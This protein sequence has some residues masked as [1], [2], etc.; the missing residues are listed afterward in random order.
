MLVNLNEE[1]IEFIMDA[2]SFYEDAGL[3][4][5]EDVEYIELLLKE[6]PT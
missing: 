5:L 1:Q 6:K 3:C 2:L 4:D